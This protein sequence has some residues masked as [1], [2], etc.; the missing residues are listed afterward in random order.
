MNINEIAQL[1]GVSRATVSRYLNDG[2][3]SE[4]KKEAIRL[5]IEKTGYEP[6]SQAQNLRR[7]VTKLIGVIIP[8][9]Q[10][11]SIGRMVDG[12]SDVL[13]AQGYKMLL[14]NTRNDV[15]E[16]LKYLK[17]FKKNQ[18]DGV[19][20]IGTIFTKAHFQAMRELEVPIVVLGQQMEQFS[21]VYQDDYQAAKSAATE[22]LRGG[23]NIGYIGV[24]T[25]DIAAGSERRRGFTDVMNQQSGKGI[26]AMLEGDFDVKSGHDKAQMLMRNF[27]K[28]DSIFCATDSIAVGALKYLKDHGISVPQQV[29]L[30]GFGD[31]VTGKVVSPTLT[32]IHFYYKTSGKEAARLL[33]E[34]LET[35]EDHKKALKMGFELKSNGSTRKE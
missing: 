35:G 1:A 19:L 17:L 5:V 14:A 9:L 10:S 2:Y 20:F 27:P 30:I 28:T 23:N 21:C 8:R 34:I 29:Q 31:T 12:I 33:L 25:K 7:Q 26:T 3:V 6:S 11:E 15:K 32:T 24:T 4:E 18:V 13:S 22:L 16:E